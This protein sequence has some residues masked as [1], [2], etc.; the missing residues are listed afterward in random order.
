MPG[1]WAASI[2]LSNNT[3]NEKSTIEVSDLP[4]IVEVYTA[5]W[6]FNC[7]ETEIALDEAIGSHEVLRFHYQRYLYETL[8]PFG[9]ES[10]ESRWLE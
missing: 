8:A 10:S 9:S 3:T 5:T 4:S 1:Q 6:C 2:L 7:V